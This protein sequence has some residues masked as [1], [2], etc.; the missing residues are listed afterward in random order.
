MPLLIR[1][2]LILVKTEVTYG[3]DPTPT[4]AA[5]AVLVRNLAVT[6]LQ[7]DVVSRDLIRPYMGASEQLL[8]NTRVQ[9]TFSVELAGSGTAGT[10]PRYDAA[11]K[12]CGLSA[13]TISSPVTGTATAGAL[14]SITLAAG[15]S[16]TNDFYNGQILRI[17]GG[18]G[19]G[20]IA[21]IT[22]YVGATK[23]ATLRTLGSSVTPDNTSAYS[24]GAQVYYLPV[25]SAFS[26]ATIY[27]NIDGVLHKLT[28]CRGTFTLNTAVGQIPSIDFTM[29]GIYNAPTDTAAPAVTYANQATPQIFKQGNSG[30]FSLYSYSGCLQSVT[31]DMGNTLVYRELVG[32]VKEVLLTNRAS[33]GTV[34]IEAPTIAS[35]DYFTA[36]LT[37]GTLGDLSFLHGSSAGS[38]VGLYSTRVDI[39]DPSYSDQDGIQMLNLPYTAV[40]STAGNDEHRLIYA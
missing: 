35:K 24:I 38:I 16:G 26:S 33:T 8:A 13:T 31:M 23:V 28:G 36:A 22:A 37:D 14:N 6:P 15:A 7:S 20:A 17:T 21:L 12:A 30:A 27:Y 10:A 19:S 2:S 9:C 1:K 11:L 3:V 18:T 32:C 5:D 39:G 25:S 4:G 29:T 40:P 34:M